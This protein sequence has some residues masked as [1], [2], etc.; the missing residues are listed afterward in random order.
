MKL[1][2]HLVAGPHKLWVKAMRT[3]YSIKDDNSVV[4]NM[5]NVILTLE[6]RFSSLTLCLRRWL[7]ARHYFR[8]CTNSLC[9]TIVNCSYQTFLFG[10]ASI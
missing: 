5:T 7:E 10:E 6:G 4:N 3:K 2:W 9:D 8:T 1:G